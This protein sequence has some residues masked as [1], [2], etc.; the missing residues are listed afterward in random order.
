MVLYTKLALVD[1][2][3]RQAERKPIDKIT[4]RE[5]VAATKMNPKTFYYHFNGISELMKWFLQRELRAIFENCPVSAEEDWDEAVIRIMDYLEDNQ[6]LLK[7]IADSKYWYEMRFFLCDMYE[8]YIA[9][10]MRGMIN[11]VQRVDGVPTSLSDEDFELNV[12][13]YGLLFY[14]LGERWFFGGM[15]EPK[16]EYVRK[17]VKVFGEENMP[18]SIRRFRKQ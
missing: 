6:K 13:F 11:R 15:K 9:E 5:L 16:R 14:S 8:E 7:S 10:L 18:D 2:F 3:K 17:C 12:S 1:E 4:V